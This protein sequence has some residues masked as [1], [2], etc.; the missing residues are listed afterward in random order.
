MKTYEISKNVIRLYINGE[1]LLTRPINEASGDTFIKWF[2]N[3]AVD[4]G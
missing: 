3:E 2:M 4:N 1:K